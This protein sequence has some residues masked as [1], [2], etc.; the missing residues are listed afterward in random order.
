M[1]LQE[2]MLAI[3][4]SNDFS[5]DQWRKIWNDTSVRA[6]LRRQSAGLQEYLNEKDRDLVR[7]AL[8]RSPVMPL[9]ELKDH[10]YG[11]EQNIALGENPMAILWFE[12]EPHFV[13]IL[14]SAEKAKLSGL[15][16]NLVFDIHGEMSYRKS[17]AIRLRRMKLLLGMLESKF[18]K[19]HV[20]QEQLEDMAKR[21]REQD[22]IAALSLV[23]GNIAR[24]WPPE[25]SMATKA[26]LAH[27]LLRDVCLALGVIP[28]RTAMH[29]LDPPNHDDLRLLLPKGQVPGLGPERG[30]EHPAEGIVRW[31]SLEHARLVAWSQEMPVAALLVNL[32]GTPVASYTTNEGTEA[33]WPEKLAALA[34]PR[35]PRR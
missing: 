7:C 1:T 16:N 5:E 10:P 28:Q 17:T 32:E 11:D 15:E 6:K 18:W 2:E 29:F 19:N 21:I 24:S 14:F 22:T 8:L 26:L 34:S 3:I 12:S 23:C 4:Q 13:E 20:P 25:I 9:E 35:R 31:T 27:R 30:S 33:G